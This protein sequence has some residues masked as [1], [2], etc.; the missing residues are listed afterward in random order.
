MKKLYFLFIAILISPASFAQATLPI[1]ETFSYTDGSLIGNGGWLNH[2]GTSG[3]LLV[4]SGQAVVEHGTPSEDANLPF[5]TVTGSIYYAF[6]FSVDDLGA[7]YSGSDNEYFAHFMVGT[8]SFSARLDIVPPT[9]SGDFSVGIATI[10]STAEAIWATDLIYGTT[11]RVTVGYNQ[12]TNQAQLWIDASVESDTSILGADE[13]DPG[14]SITA[15]ALRQSDSSENETIRIDNLV[16]AQSFD[17]VLGV[18]EKNQIEGF[19][20][21]PNPTALGYVKISSKSNANMEVAVFDVLGKQIIK[22]TV[23][24]N[25]L[26]V[27]NLKSGIYIMKVSQDNATSTKKLVIE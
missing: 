11:Y 13:A 8:G 10:S 16:I 25:V 5:T 4:S 27:S 12:N 1:S 22:N 14:N 2:S 26:D 6:D 7:A 18:K 20:M 17:S 19:A 21:Y 9:L 23:K 3:D 15:F 24:D